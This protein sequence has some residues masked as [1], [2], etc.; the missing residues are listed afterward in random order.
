MDHM[1]G[2]NKSTRVERVTH[3]CKTL[4]MSCQLESHWAADEKKIPIWLTCGSPGSGSTNGYSHKKEENGVHPKCEAGPE[5]SRA[6]LT[7][8]LLV[9][10]GGALCLMSFCSAS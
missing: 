8:F 10:L 7:M 2:T 4:Q 3:C 9:Y 1:G 5:S 6:L